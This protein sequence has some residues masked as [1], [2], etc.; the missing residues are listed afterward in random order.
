MIDKKDIT[1]TKLARPVAVVDLWDLDDRISQLQD[2][3]ERLEKCIHALIL[4]HNKE[5]VRDWELLLR[6]VLKGERDKVEKNKPIFE[7]EGEDNNDL[8]SIFEEKDT[9]EPPDDMWAL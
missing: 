6:E 4:I 8:K 5:N 7:V 2:C 9:L 1:D 3:V